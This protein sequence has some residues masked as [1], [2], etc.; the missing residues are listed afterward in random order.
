MQS[1]IKSGLRDFSISRAAVDWGIPVP[2]DNKQTIYVWF[3]ALLGYCSF[4]IQKE[5]MVDF[6]FL[7]LNVI[8]MFSF[9]FF[10]IVKMQVKLIIFYRLIGV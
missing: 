10:S 5:I 4:L 7:D 8:R 6:L 3:D 2:N 1:W 9:L